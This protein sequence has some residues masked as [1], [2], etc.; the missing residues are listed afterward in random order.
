[1]VSVVLSAV[2]GRFVECWSEHVGYEVS[3]SPQLLSCTY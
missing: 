2:G 1:M 3:N